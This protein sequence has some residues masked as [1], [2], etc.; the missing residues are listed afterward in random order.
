MA[1]LAIIP[2]RSGSKGLPDKN[3]RDLCGKPML[4]YT[5]QAAVESG[6]FSTIHVST[7]SKRYA[8]I[9]Q[10]F[11]ADVPFLRDIE[12]AG[13][14]SSSWDVVKEVLEKYKERNQTF[15]CVFLLQPTSPL[16]NADDIKNVYRLM[17]E[18]KARAII[19][20]CEAEH[21]PVWCNTLPESGT[22]ESFLSRH[23]AMPRQS[24]ATYY[25]LNGA[26]YCVTTPSV[27]R[28]ETLYSSE[29]YAYIMPKERSVDVDD[30]YDFIYAEALLR[31]RSDA[32]K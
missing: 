18:R 28:Q 6:I 9:A 30:V 19:S 16:R 24:L 11:G 32:M 15:S 17:H 8:E 7:E 14:I 31:Y 4:A 3:I 26:I 2:A 1:V 12:T 10:E 20:V 13:D 21:S 22:M 27:Y 5:I 25:R 23:A 29:S